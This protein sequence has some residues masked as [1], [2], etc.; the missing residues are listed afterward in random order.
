MSKQ[1]KK[2]NTDTDQSPLGALTTVKTVYARAVML[3][4]A[5]NFCLTG[6]AV[7]SLTQLQTEAFSDQSVVPTQE[8]RSA[9]T[10]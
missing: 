1:T 4:L 10:E 7:Y 3:L 2:Q 5:F 9:S 6:Y 8:M